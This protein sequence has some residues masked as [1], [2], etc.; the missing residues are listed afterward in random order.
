MNPKTYRP[1]LTLIVCLAVSGGF[2][3]EALG[4]QWTNR[5]EILPWKLIPELTTVFREALGRIR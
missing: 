4:Q 5:P 2:G 1:I 3:I